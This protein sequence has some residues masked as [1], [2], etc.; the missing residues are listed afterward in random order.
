MIELALKAKILRSGM[1]ISAGFWDYGRCTDAWYE[2]SGALTAKY[3]K[4]SGDSPLLSRRSPRP[5]ISEHPPK[6]SLT[7]E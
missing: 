6:A 5:V 4:R 3:M 7:L 1:T 2:Q